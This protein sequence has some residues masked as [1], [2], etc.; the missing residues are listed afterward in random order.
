MA[1]HQ[2]PGSLRARSERLMMDLRGAILDRRQIE[3]GYL[4][5][6]RIVQPAVLGLHRVSGQLTLRGYQVGGRSNSRRPPYW[7]LFPVARIEGLRVSEQAFDDDPPGY[8]NG[9]VYAH[10]IY[11]AL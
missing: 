10:P 3:F 5:Q 6:P 8:R 4:G 1:S 9:H 7:I 2:T 11:A